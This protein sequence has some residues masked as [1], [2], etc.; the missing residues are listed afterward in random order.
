ML[1]ET[2]TEARLVRLE[3]A[4]KVLVLIVLI[5][6]AFGARSLPEPHHSVRAR[7]IQLLDSEGKVAAELTTRDGVPGLYILDAGGKT[8]VSLFHSS[9]ATGLYVNDQDEVT[10]IGVAQ[11]SH[12]GGGVAL[13]GP[14]SKGAAVLYFK[15]SGSLRFF[16][17]EGK[18]TNGVFA[19]PK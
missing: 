2:T 8:R 15:D 14:E 6:F 10:R 4:N 17:A 18:V 3:V 5:A 11:F 12:G 19:T 1:N 9:E 16:D 7:S 13:H